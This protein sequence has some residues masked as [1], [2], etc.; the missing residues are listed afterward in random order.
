MTPRSQGSHRYTRLLFQDDLAHAGHDGG[1]DTAGDRQRDKPCQDDVA[2]DRPVN[3]LARTE[4][5]DEDDGADL[6]VS[7]TDG[8]A[9]VGRDQHRQRR[10]DLNAETTVVIENGGLI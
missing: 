4:V 6:A 1:T 8:N 10:P 7:R 5:A 9:D 3:V 2:E